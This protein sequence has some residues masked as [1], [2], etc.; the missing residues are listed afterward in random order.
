MAL[1]ENSMAALERSR[2]CAGCTE[3]LLAGL[4]EAR[5]ALDALDGDWMEIGWILDGDWMHWMEIGWIGWR[6]DGDWMHWMEIGY[7]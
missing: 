2:G 1:A 6:V 5:T 4:L 3:G 7:E